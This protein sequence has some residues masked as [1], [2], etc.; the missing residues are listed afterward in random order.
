MKM[1]SKVTEALKSQ[2]KPIVALEST[3]ISHGMPWPENYKC[4]LAVEEL[5]TGQGAV[6]ATIAIINGLIHV[7]LEQEQLERFAQYPREAVRKCSRRDIAVAVGLKETG[8]TTVSGTIWIAKSCGIE[9]FVTGGIG[10]VHRGAF[11]ESATVDVSADLTELGRS[12]MTVVCAG[13]KSILDI[14]HTIEWLETQGVTVLTY[15]KS[16]QPN[17]PSFFTQS[18][19]VKSPLV[20]DKIIDVASIVHAN[21]TLELD[22]SV[23]VAV[24]NPFPADEDKV[25]AA[26]QQGLHNLGNI[27]GKEVTPFLLQYVNEATGGNSLESN[28]A[29]VKNNAIVGAQLACKVHAM[30]HKR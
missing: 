11:G 24:P 15:S 12:G 4:A 27:S 1:S 23:L 22:S 6:P 21:R 9:T 30:N 26:I 7:G 29:L 13:V 2:T 28:I 17:F 5:V 20:C 19:S 3:I 16:N 10:G 8:A 14:P 25:Q 18:S